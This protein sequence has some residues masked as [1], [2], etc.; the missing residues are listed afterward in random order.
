MKNPYVSLLKTAWQYAGKRR[1]TFLL[2]YT[3]LLASQI[4]GFLQP[5]WF[6]RFVGRVQADPKGVMTSTLWFV[7]G[8]AAL[9]LL[10]WSFHGPARI[11]ERNLAF[12]IG[13]NFLKERYHQTLHLTA[14]W[15]QDHHSGATINRIQKAYEG[16]RGFYD[17]GFSYLYTLCKF[18]LSV[19]AIL[20]F[21]PLFGAV[22]VAL[23]AVNLFII[24]KFDKAYIKTL[25]Q[26]A[27]KEHGVTSNLFDTLSNIR[28]VITLRLERSMEISL[29]AKLRKVYPPFRRLAVVNEWKWFLADMMITLIYGVVV[30]GYV[31]QHWKPGEAFPLA[32]LVVLVGYVN[33]FTGGFSS[34]A[35]QYTSI[36]E[37]YT[38]V[39]EANVIEEAYAAQHRADKPCHFPKAWHTMEINGLSYAH[40]TKAFNKKAPQLHNV[41]L[42]LERGKKVALIGSSGS[43]KSTLLSLL[44]GLYTPQGGVGF[45][46]DGRKYAFGCLNESTTL[47]PQEP[48]I[49]EN[50]VL[51]NITL[52]LPFSDEAIGAACSAAHLSNVI[53]ELPG[54]LHT[55][56][57][58]KG[59]NLSGGQKQRLALARG[60]LAG[61]DSQLVLLDEPTSSIDPKTEAGIYEKLFE[62]FRDKVIVSSIHRMHLLPQFDYI[63]LM[64]A[65][66]ILAEGSFDD[67]M[68]NSKAFREQWYHQQGKE[69]V[70]AA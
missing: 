17:R 34:V 66:R 61:I 22:A 46:V 16:L 23:G 57:C 6:G 15:H 31:Y 55:D 60:V 29:L 28:T 39:Q 51:Y 14:Q 37:S 25:R 20:Y 32:T 65:G 35:G 21:S 63:Y 50:T 18:V 58:E 43:G 45:L 42:K 10:E 7:A 52:G 53:N 36:V 41:K 48:E 24:S 44:R 27:K 19:C 11:M 56:I 1:K 12:Y 68:Q 38:Q 40:Q 62:A 54:G 13:R 5:L 67:L 2:I 26:V 8:Y 64:E 33:Q 70:V 4:V 69:F 9:K 49:F 47:F 30:A 59:V 3:L